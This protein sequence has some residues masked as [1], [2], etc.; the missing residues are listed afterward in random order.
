MTRG[1]NSI[2]TFHFQTDDRT[3]YSSLASKESLFLMNERD[4]RIG[5]WNCWGKVNR[6]SVFFMSIRWT[7]EE[8]NACGLS[9]I[10]INVVEIWKLSYLLSLC[11]ET[12][13]CK[14]RIFL[15]VLFFRILIFR[16]HVPIS[17]H[18]SSIPKS[19]Q[20]TVDCCCSA[21]WYFPPGQSRKPTD[22]EIDVNREG[23]FKVLSSLS[24]K[25]LFQ[26]TINTLTFFR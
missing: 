16:R 19:C 22:V 18:S 17:L 3:A 6:E 4:V 20:P 24:S 9:M 1:K 12:A 15:L 21:G 5:K 13:D 25:S 2:P 7:R 10:T 11:F 14:V 23:G 26:R 8:P